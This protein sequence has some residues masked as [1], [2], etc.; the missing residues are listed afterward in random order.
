LKITQ[1]V[2]GNVVRFDSYRQGFFV[3]ILETV[4]KNYSFIVPIDDIG[5]ATM[6]AE[7]KAITFMRWIRKALEDKTLIELK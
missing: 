6:L 1:L 3:Y 4:D 5:T 2:K 7:D